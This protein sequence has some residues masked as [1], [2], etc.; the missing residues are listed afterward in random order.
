MGKLWDWDVKLWRSENDEIK[1][2]KPW[3]RVWEEH[4]QELS[5]SDVWQP[6][7]ISIGFQTLWLDQDFLIFSLNLGGC[8]T[9]ACREHW[10]GWQCWRG[11][12]LAGCPGSEPCS[13]TLSS[14]SEEGQDY[15]EVDHQEGGQDGQKVHNV[16][17]NTIM[18]DQIQCRYDCNGCFDEALMM[19]CEMRVTVRVESRQR[20]LF[21]VWLISQC[22]PFTELETIVSSIY[23]KE[24]RME[25][26][27]RGKD[28]CWND[29]FVNV[30]NTRREDDIRWMEWGKGLL[31]KR[32]ICFLSVKLTASV[33]RSVGND[34]SCIY[35]NR[36]QMG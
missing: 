6:G 17:S 14:P 20:L 2:D 25:G 36:G 7:N 5:Q 8:H 32:L 13:L 21:D 9:P 19:A 26:G 15:H 28:F 31:F 24:K 35:E 29:W 3:R 23:Q 33:N 34:T 18:C 11:R 1:D 16:W 27:Q 12:L 22:F 10:R 4:R 30:Q